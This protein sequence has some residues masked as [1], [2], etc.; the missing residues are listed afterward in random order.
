MSSATVLLHGD[1]YPSLHELVM[2]VGRLELADAR[3]GLVELAGEEVLLFVF[4]TN[5]WY[6]VGRYFFARVANE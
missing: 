5:V 1:A 3:C 2:E 6:Y 4:V